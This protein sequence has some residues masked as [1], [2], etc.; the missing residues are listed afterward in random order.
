VLC[1]LLVGRANLYAPQ[2]ERDVRI[3]PDVGIDSSL[4]LLNDVL[5]SE[6]ADPA[7]IY[8]AEFRSWRAAFGQDLEGRVVRLRFIVSNYMMPPKFAGRVG[9]M[10]AFS[11]DPNGDTYYY[12]YLLNPRN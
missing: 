11:T 6:T 4:P 8:W 9:Y 7:P 5:A 10:P 1:R 3:D 2:L 12:A